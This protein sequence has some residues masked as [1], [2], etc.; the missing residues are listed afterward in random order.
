MIYVP[1]Y[2]D[3]YFQSAEKKNFLTATLSIRNISF[4]DSFYATK[5]DY[6]GSSGEQIKRYIDSAILVTP[7]ASVKFIVEEREKKVAP[8]LTLLFHGM[9]KK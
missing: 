5:V 8:V 4:T 3:I 1:V 6:Y 7:M 9:Q 2:S